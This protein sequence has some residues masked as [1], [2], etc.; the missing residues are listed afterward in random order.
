MTEADK[1]GY[2][3]LVS[4]KEMEYAITFNTSKQITFSKDL[5]DHLIAENDG[6]T[7]G[8]GVNL[9]HS[10]RGKGLKIE[11]VREAP[12]VKEKVH[13][14]LR[15]NKQNNRL[16]FSGRNFIKGIGVPVLG[17]RWGHSAIDIKP[18]GLDLDLT[19]RAV[20]TKRRRKTST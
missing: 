5:T 1:K 20:N 7:D 4:T 13:A 2:A 14:E 12:V 16:C 10:N 11:V 19:K 6:K 18:Y 3:L 15:I 8:L 9:W 17:K